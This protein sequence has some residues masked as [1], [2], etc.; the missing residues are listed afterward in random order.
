MN[1]TA[2]GPRRSGRR[3][4]SPTPRHQRGVGAVL[5]SLGEFDQGRLL[6]LGEIRWLPTDTDLT[7]IGEPAPH[8]GIVLHGAVVTRSAGVYDQTVVTDVLGPGD[9]V[10]ATEALT[11]SR[12]SRTTLSVAMPTQ[13]LTLPTPDFLVL[14]GQSASVASFVAEHLAAQVASREVDAAVLATA[15]ALTA[16]VWRLVQMATRWSVQVDDDLHIEVTITQEDLGR[17]AGVSRESAVRSLHL[18]REQGLVDTGRRS[19]RVL[20]LGG[21][22]Q[23]L[24]GRGGQSVVGRT[25][26][27]R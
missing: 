16:V 4:R 6:D 26:L 1:G 10:G 25:G 22:Q 3:P 15:D 13:L 23:I 27:R 21:L 17:W 2:V 18:L 7:R 24:E 12:V 8:V 19:V 11:G 5:E 14:L 9:L 20:D